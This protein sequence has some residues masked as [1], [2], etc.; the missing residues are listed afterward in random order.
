MTYSY[1]ELVLDIRYS[2]M[3]LI[4]YMELGLTFSLLTQ[5]YRLRRSE[6][7]SRR[8]VGIVW[9]DLSVRGG[10]STGTI[11]H[12]RIFNGVKLLHPFEER[13]SLKNFAMRRGGLVARYEK[14]SEINHFFLQIEVR[15]ILQGG[16][17]AG[18]FHWMIFSCERVFMKEE[19]DMPVLFK[20]Q[21]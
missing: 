18:I 13:S 9:E 12:E 6:G 8:K 2:Y 11:L 4:G 1:T 15:R 14:L 5:F 7:L 21:E 10:F 20:N 16:L 3:E 17:S 19:G